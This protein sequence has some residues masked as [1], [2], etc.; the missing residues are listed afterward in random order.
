[1]SST[2]RQKEIIAVAR[3]II[4]NRGMK[5]LTV[6]QIANDL[7]ITDGALYRHFKSK[8]EI[9]ALMIDDIEETLLSVI[10]E[11]V[12]KNWNPLNRLEAVFFSHLSYAEQRRGTSFLVINET[13][14]IK[15]K[16][17]ESKMSAVLK[18]YLSM[19][20]DIL[21]EGIK[22]GDFV[23]DTD[24]DAASIVFFGLVQSA[25]TFWS[26]SGQKSMLNH[27]QLNGMWDVYRKGIVRR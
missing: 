7:G 26:L 19:I 4:V 6:R 15:D 21:N 22:K 1:M 25:I 14:G 24:V 8:K 10:K 12:D 11:E 2:I 3:N 27:D 9:L 13:L 20:K 18:K 23:K 17:L 16:G 5:S